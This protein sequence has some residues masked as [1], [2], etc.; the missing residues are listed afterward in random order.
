MLGSADLMEDDDGDYVEICRTPGLMNHR[1]NY[2]SAIVVLHETD[3]MIC[4]HNP[5]AALPIVNKD[6]CKLFA[7]QET[8]VFGDKKMTW[9]EI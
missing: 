7:Y 3:N 6:V 4:F 9:K 8:A 5:N 1:M 2:I